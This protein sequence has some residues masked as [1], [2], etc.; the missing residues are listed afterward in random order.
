MVSVQSRL[1]RSGAQF[2]ID[3]KCPNMLATFRFNDWDCD[4]RVRLVASSGWTLV[5]KSVVETRGTCPDGVD[6]PFDP[7][8]IG[9]DERVG[10]DLPTL[11]ISSA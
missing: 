1:R 5:P 8:E 4:A 6:V 9:T 2:G 11:C 3:H 7:L 10:M